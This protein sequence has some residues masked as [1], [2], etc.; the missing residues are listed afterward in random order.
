MQANRLGNVLEAWTVLDD[1]DVQDLDL[2]VLE[3]NS[4]EDVIPGHLM[5]EIDGIV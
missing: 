2:E 1:V 3:E 4:L 5:K